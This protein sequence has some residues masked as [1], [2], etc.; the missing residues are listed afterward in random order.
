VE[1]RRGVELAAARNHD[2]SSRLAAECGRDEIGVAERHALGGACRAARVEDPGDGVA[3]TPGVGDRLTARDQVLVGDHTAGRRF[4]PGM[5][6]VPQ[7]RRVVPHCERDR[8]HDVVDD[9]YG[10]LGVVE[11]VCDLALV[12]ANVEGNDDAVG[13][14]DR[15][16]RLDVAIRVQRQDCYP[17]TLGQPEGPEPPCQPG[18]PVRVLGN[19]PDAVTGDGGQRAGFIAQRAMQ[20]L[21]EVHGLRPSLQVAE[22]GCAGCVGQRSQ[23]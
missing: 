11:G 21:R 17:A 7:R 19:G 13:P 5:N 20:S 9:Q 12:P 6:H 1:H 2:R 4:V 23:S 22:L 3:A 15:E 18:H 16:Q 10:R 8:R 14:W